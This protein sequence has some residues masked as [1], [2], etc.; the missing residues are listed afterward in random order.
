MDFDAFAAAAG[1]KLRGALVGAYGAEVGREA[2]AE[3]L[4]YAW[5]HRAR[6]EAMENP[7]GYLYR[8]GQTAAR[9]LRRTGPL[10]PAAPPTAE[11]HIEPGLPDAL[12]ALTEMQRQCVV[13][14]H[15][16]GYGQTEVAEL[17]GVS[18]STVR[19]HL[20]RGLTALRAALA[21]EE[22]TP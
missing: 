14:V 1:H 5:E 7:V 15:G 13:L 21:P 22:V 20:D 8:V 12:A 2:A 19:T 3:A 17:L 9:K 10:F 16:Y 11:L 4:A 6:V 18:P